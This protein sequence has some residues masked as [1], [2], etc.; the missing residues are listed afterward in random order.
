MMLLYGKEVGKTG[1][2]NNLEC[3]WI[4]REGKIWKGAE[5]SECSRRAR[6]GVIVEHRPK[7]QNSHGESRLGLRC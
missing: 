5:P 4:I 6:R 3:K 2:H 1:S 7:P